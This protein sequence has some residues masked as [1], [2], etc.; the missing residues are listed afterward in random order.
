MAVNQGK[1]NTLWPQGQR[2]C[3][4]DGLCRFLCQSHKLQFFSGVL[5]IATTT[6]LNLSTD[7][8]RDVQFLAYSC[9][10]E[11][12]G[13]GWWG[14]RRVST[15]S[16]SNPTWRKGEAVTIPTSKLT[17]MHQNPWFFEAFFSKGK[18]QRCPQ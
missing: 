14:K 10:T 8:P 11:A 13:K 5:V 15:L 3:T 18:Q 4:W 16:Q 17:T 2:E 7:V 9:V 1:E 12:A 6:N